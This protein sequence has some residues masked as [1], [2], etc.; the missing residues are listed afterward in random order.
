MKRQVALHFIP[1][2]Y[3]ETACSAGFLAYAHGSLFQ[4]SNATIYSV[5]IFFATWS[6]YNLLRVVSLFRRVQSELNWRTVPDLMFVPFH[7]A[8]ATL[9]GLTAVVLLFFLESDFNGLL[10]LGVLF[11]VTLSYR[12]RW[13]RHQGRSIALSEF[14]YIKSLLV[15][16]VWTLICSMIPSG[17]AEKNALLYFS[18]FLYILGLSIPFD[19]RD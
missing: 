10:L 11:F 19:I 1:R 18:F 17:L 12:F 9:S 13:F 7:I 15:A 2:A 3:F 5:F 8:L 6:I 4:S 16:A 14:P